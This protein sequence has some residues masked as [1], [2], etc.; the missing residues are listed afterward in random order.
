MIIYP[1]IVCANGCHS[2]ECVCTRFRKD[3]GCLI[4]SG[5]TKL[6][7]LV[8]GLISIFWVLCLCNCTAGQS[9]RKTK[10]I[11]Y[12]SLEQVPLIDRY[13]LEAAYEIQQNWV[14]PVQLGAMD[15][16]NVASVIFKIMPNGSI[17]DIVIV[18]KSGDHSLDRA[19]FEAIERVSSLKPHPEGLSQPYVEMGLRIGDQGVR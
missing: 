13:R 12:N 19:A 11:Y 15:T 6:A 1:A 7:L 16:N 2:G 14:R 3:T 17:K 5:M 9:I 8:T 4:K 10:V 18:E